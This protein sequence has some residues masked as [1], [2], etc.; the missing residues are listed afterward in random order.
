MGHDRVRSS[1]PYWEERGATF[2]DPDG[3]RIV[4]E[5]AAWTPS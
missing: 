5:N 3:Y 2:E 1:N 4:F